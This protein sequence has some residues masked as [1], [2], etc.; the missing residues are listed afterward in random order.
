[1]KDTECDE[2]PG[3]EP[4]F[5]PKKRRFRDIHRGN[6][7]VGCAAVNAATDL[8]EHKGGSLINE[9]SSLVSLQVYLFL[10]AVREVLNGFQRSEY[11]VVAFLTP[12]LIAD[13]HTNSE[14]KVNAA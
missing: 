13:C 5:C 8:V 2:D 12:V 3:G 4:S 11:F 14:K 9:E 10:G 1:M 7:S 6:V